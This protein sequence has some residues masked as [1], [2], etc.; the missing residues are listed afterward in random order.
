LH[1]AVLLIF[2]F[3]IL[4]AGQNLEKNRLHTLL[5]QANLADKESTA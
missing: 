4:P 5:P 3:Q 2:F 1:A